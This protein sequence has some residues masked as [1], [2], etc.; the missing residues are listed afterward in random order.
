MEK[1]SNVAGAV[2]SWLKADLLLRRCSSRIMMMTIRDYDNNN[3]VTILSFL[4]NHWPPNFVFLVATRTFCSLEYLRDSTQFEWVSLVRT[5]AGQKRIP[6]LMLS[7]IVQD[8]FVNQI[9]LKAGTLFVKGHDKLID[10]LRLV[11]FVDWDCWS[12]IIISKYLAFLML[13]S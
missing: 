1:R 9:D 7:A 6:G 8:V 11:S 3:G 12:N 4:R 10:C 13:L 5:R 2:T